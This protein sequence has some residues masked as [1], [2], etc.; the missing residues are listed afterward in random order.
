MTCVGERQTQKLREL[1]VKSILSQEIGWFD[2]CGAGE[3]AT[4]LA[5]LTGKVQGAFSFAF[6]TLSHITHIPFS[7]IAILL[8]RYFLPPP[9]KKIGMLFRWHREE[10]WRPRPVR[11]PSH[12]L[13]RRW[14]LS[15][16]AAHIGAYLRLSPDCW[17]WSLYDRCDYGR[18]GNF[19]IITSFP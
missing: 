7:S 5:E 14:F 6:G 17:R 9:Q 15:V 10:D 18:P 3:L 11:V 16:L 13:F 12:R 8:N 19:I 1:Y 4:K 2:T